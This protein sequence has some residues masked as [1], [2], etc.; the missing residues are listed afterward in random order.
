MFTRFLAGA[1]A[2]SLCLFVAGCGGDQIGSTP[3]PTPTPVVYDTV[4]TMLS[5]PGDK[6]FQT[7]GTRWRGVIGERTTDFRS[8]AFGAASNIEYVSASDAYRVVMGDGASVLFPLADAFNND[9]GNQVEQVISAKGDSKNSQLVLITPEISNVPLSYLRFASFGYQ[10]SAGNYETNRVIW[11]AQTQQADMPRKGSASYRLSLFGSASA[12]GRYY[13][14][15]DRS[16]GTLSANFA[17]GSIAS[18]LT[19]KSSWGDNPVNVGTLSGSGTIDSSG[20]GFVGTM[21]GSDG[22]ANS[23]HFGGAFFGPAAKEVGFSWVYDGPAIYSEGWA[24]G[25]RD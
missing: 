17:N 23:A 12:N 8:V 19:L 21:T 22:P 20:V 5:R 1:S 15:D 4:S 7:G 16:S 6:T 3:T 2:L 10:D 11:G 13:S 25:G 18:T 24:A 9:S 14:L